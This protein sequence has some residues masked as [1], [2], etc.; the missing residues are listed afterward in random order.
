VTDR[1][2]VRS[3]VL[4]DIDGTLIA[5]SVGHLVVLGEVLARHLGRPVP[6]RVDGERPMLGDT[7]LAGWVDSQVVRAVLRGDSPNPPDEAEVVAVLAAFERDYTPAAAARHSTPSVID[8]V[9]DCLARLGAAG[10]PMG[11]VTGNA[12][13]VAR[14]K[15]ASLGLERHFRFERDL[16]FGDWRADRSAVGAAGVA[17]MELDA[18]GSDGIAYVGDTPSDMRAAVAAGV[19]P[20]GVLTGSGTVETLTKAGAAVILRSVASIY[21]AAR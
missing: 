10:I 18:G 6:I 17:A 9:A 15:L 8:G 20:V 4:F 7:E 3:G 21:P 11:L 12:S 1:L 19:L 13:F 2:E 5:G 16:G 14:A